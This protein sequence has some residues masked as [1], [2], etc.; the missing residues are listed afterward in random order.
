MLRFNVN[1]K[2]DLVYI[3]V[4]NFV[5]IKVYSSMPVLSNYNGRK[6]GLSTEIRNL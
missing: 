3:C 5:V 6:S 2:C 4:L 1:E